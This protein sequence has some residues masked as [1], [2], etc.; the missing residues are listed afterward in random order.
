MSLP[1]IS[2]E[3]ISKKFTLDLK[4]GLY[5]GLVDTLSIMSGIKPS[6]DKLRPREFW[7]LQNISF[8]VNQGESL[9]LVGCNGSGKTTLLRLIS[10][11]YPPSKGTIKIRGEIGSLIAVGAGFH[12][13]MTGRENIFLNGSL[14]GMSVRD[15]QHRFDD[16]VEFAEVNTF[17]DSPVAT[18]SS[19]MSLRLAFSVAI[20]CNVDILLADEILAVGDEQFRRKCT[21]RMKELKRKGLSLIMVSHVAQQIEENCERV[22]LID[23]GIQKFYGDVDEGL[24]LYDEIQKNNGLY[25]PPVGPHPTD[26]TV[27]DFHVEKLYMF[28]NYIDGKCTISPGGSF[29]LDFAY[30]A[31]K[32]YA[33]LNIKLCFRVPSIIQDNYVEITGESIGQY[34]SVVKGSGRISI[35]VEHLPFNG[36]EV[37]LYPEIWDADMGECLYGHREIRLHISENPTQVGYGFFPV[38]LSLKRD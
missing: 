23:K 20:H 7:A 18:Y 36:L 27:T 38:K 22:V 12:P 19:G 2:V 32:D 30:Q 3:N 35:L 8:T 10:G 15:L 34:L 25:V 37:L 4:R 13:H 31:T 33:K 6:N 17:I 5:Y 16:I 14:L 29:T 26:T 21:K 24:S 1:L 11:I 28:P 9:A